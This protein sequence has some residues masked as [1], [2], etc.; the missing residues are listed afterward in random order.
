MSSPVRLPK[1]YAF[2]ATVTL[3]ENNASSFQSLAKRSLISKCNWNFTI[4]NFCSSDG[5]YSD[6]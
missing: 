3:D 5:G 1:S 2:A 6:L 4:N